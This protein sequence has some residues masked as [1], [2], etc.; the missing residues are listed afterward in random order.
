MSENDSG[1]SAIKIILR[2]LGVVAI[3]CAC[4]VALVVGRQEYRDYQREIVVK[5]ALECEEVSKQTDAQAKS[6]PWRRLLLGRRGEQ[7]PN[8]FAW[9][10]P[11]EGIPR[12]LDLGVLDK[13]KVETNRFIFYDFGGAI[14]VTGVDNFNKFE[15]RS[16]EY[17]ISATDGD[18]LLTGHLN[19]RT[20]MWTQTA[21][22]E[23]SPSKTKQCE[24]IE[25]E[26][27]HKAIRIVQSAAPVNKI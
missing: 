11:K 22:G 1:K 27:M 4:F 7:L 8:N 18:T 10:M 5:V 19:R 17:R 23:I 24:Q 16:D 21:D 25:P 9:P 3:V 20:L 2:I 6:E 14:Y 26:A 12:A 15:A 13:G